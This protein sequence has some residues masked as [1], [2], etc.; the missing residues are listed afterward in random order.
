MIIVLAPNDDRVVRAAR[1]QS[2]NFPGIFGETYIAGRDAVPEAG[3]TEAV[4]FF[5]HGTSLGDSGNAEIGEK[6][7]D[8]ALDGLE[9]WDN[10]KDVFPDL[11]T[12][13]VYV[14]AC[15]SADYPEDMFSLIET[16]RSQSAIALNDSSVFGRTGSPDISL[17]QPGTDAWTEAAI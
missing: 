14:N 3:P 10:Y 16:F 4:F 5:G 15:E 17:P 13:D 8:F 7:G 2:Y 12:G 9:L 11:Y 1:A 6:S